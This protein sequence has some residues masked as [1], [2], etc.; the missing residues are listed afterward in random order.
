MNVSSLQV[1]CGDLSIV[2]YNHINCAGA[3]RYSD[4]TGYSNTFRWAGN[5]NDK[6]QRLADNWILI[7]LMFTCLCSP[8][9][10]WGRRLTE[11]V[12]IDALRYHHYSEQFRPGFIKR[13]LNKV[14]LEK[15]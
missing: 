1:C 14:S 7:V 4:Y 2:W 10:S 15:Q 6:T 9:D 3:E 13:E 5:H 11:V 12:A 8:R